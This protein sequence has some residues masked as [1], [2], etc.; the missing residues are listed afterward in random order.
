MPDWLYTIL[1]IILFIIC[2]SL[3]I[4]VHELGH[5]IA[6]KSFGVFCNEFSIGF[7]PALLHKKKE[8][9]ETYFSIR[10]IP[11]GGYV[12][13]AGENPP[14]D[15]D[16]SDEEKDETTLLLESVP[17][18]R[19]LCNKPKWARAI[20]MVA[21]VTMNALL[22]LVI[23]F[24]GEMFFTQQGFVGLNVVEVVDD[25]PASEAGLLSFDAIKCE[26]DSNNQAYAV[27]DTGVKL[28]DS[29]DN[30]LFDNYC[31]VFKTENVSFNERDY[32][33]CLYYFKTTTVKDKE[34]HDIKVPD[35]GFPLDLNSSVY[36]N[37]AYLQANFQSFIKEE[38]ETIFTDHI[39]KLDVVNQDDV[40]KFEPIGVKTY[41]YEHNN[42]FGEALAGTFVDFGDSATAV[43]RGLGAIF[44]T[45]D[46][47]K[48]TSGIL[49]IGFTMSNYLRNYGVRIFI[50]MWGLISVNLAI[51]NLFPFPGLDGWHLLVIVIEAITKKEVPA[52]FKAIASAIGMILLIG[53]MILILFKDVFT[54]IL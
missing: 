8:N 14:T 22:A 24:V 4:V 1:F 46:G 30:L 21:G 9:S 6:A 32:D 42:T 3:L 25:T 26:V 47:W 20:V 37:V 33:H 51:F 39:I 28:Y 13:M 11:F 12:S 45:P 54:L 34:D 17:A 50:Y 10:A 44:T 18:E 43:F 49:G 52:K 36:Q 41:L 48:N 40:R 19:R 53:L 16:N 29:S 5:L 15:D 27:F 2:L 7:G 31:V 38:E 23:F 35:Y